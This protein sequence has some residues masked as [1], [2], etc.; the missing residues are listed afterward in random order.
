M[1][2]S[3]LIV[4]NGVADV[5]GLFL[6]SLEVV[7]GGIGWIKRPG[8]ISIDGKAWD[9]CANQRVDR[10]TG[11]IN[12]SGGEL[13]VDGGAAFDRRLRIRERGDRSVINTLYGYVN[14]LG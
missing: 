14:R 11:G 3:A 2:A 7:I 13:S 12:I 1:I 6:I 8:A 4:N 9:I 5:D 10:G